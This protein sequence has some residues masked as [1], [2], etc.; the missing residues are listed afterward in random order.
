ME[1]LHKWGHVNFVDLYY[2]I[3][4]QIVN[5]NGTSQWRREHVNFCKCVLTK[6]DTLSNLLNFFWIIG[7]MSC[8]LTNKVVF[9]DVTIIY[10]H[11][12][13]QNLC[14]LDSKQ[15]MCD[16]KKSYPS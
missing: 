16:I 14:V 11:F 15:Q 8:N 6:V 13:L 1:L 9:V 10:I 7:L 2:I 3:K 5:N 4:T 12:I